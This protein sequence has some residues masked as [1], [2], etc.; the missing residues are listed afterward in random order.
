MAFTG[1]LPQPELDALY[2]AAFHT[3]LANPM[4]LGSLLMGMNPFFAAT[5][6]NVALPAPAQLLTTLQRLNTTERLTDGS[7]PL[8]QWLANAVKLAGPVEDAQL[9]ARALTKVTQQATGAPSIPNVA[10]LPERKER[11]IHQDDM[12]PFSFFAGGLAAGQAVAHLRVPR[13]D[14]GAA[15]LLP[16]G[17]P[18]LNIGTAWLITPELAVTNHHVVNARHPNE[19]E[20]SQADLTLQAAHALLYFDFDDPAMLPS[21]VGVAKLEALDAT[22]DYAILRLAQRQPPSRRPLRVKTAAIPDRAP[23]NIIQHPQGGPKRVACRNNLVTAASPTELR[24][25]TDTEAGSSGAPVFDDTWHVV[26]LHRAS[27]DV[28]NVSFQGKSTAWVNLGTPLGAI[29]QDLQQRTP[30]LWQELQAAQ[31]T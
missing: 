20:S 14:S 7:V 30:M 21:P 25:F 28:T 27:V 15:T 2:Q 9:F 11:I 12:V 22:L 6:Q 13:Y 29:F 23:V 24:Y 31:A 18:Y 16:S 8:Q 26:A 19:P 5:L 10:T 17:G 4:M 3:G 1:Y